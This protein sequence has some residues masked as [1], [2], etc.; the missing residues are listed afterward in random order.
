MQF[1]LALAVAAV[2]A[3]QTSPALKR[4]ESLLVRAVIDG[5]TIDVVTIGPVHLLGIDAPSI[6]RRSETASPFGR[7]ARDRLAAL[8]LHRWIR[9][10][11][12]ITRFDAHVRR[13]AYVMREDGLFVNAVMVPEGL[14]RLSVRLPSAHLA[15]L[16]R[17]EHEAQV[18]HRGIWGHAGEARTV[19]SHGPARYTAKAKKAPRSERTPRQKRPP[20]RGKS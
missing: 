19:A 18:F 2:A 16:Q 7:E 13:P 3:A 12:E 6:G 4:S 17:A 9:L 14:T 5:D 11:R 20:P 1:L 10:E 8:V 15:E